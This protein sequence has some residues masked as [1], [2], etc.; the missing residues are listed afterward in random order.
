MNYQESLM[1]LD[2]LNTFGIKL[3]LSRIE[4]LTEL[5][6][7]PERKYKTIHV[8][9]TNGKGSVSC[10][11]AA[12]L[13]QA[14][15]RAGLYI[16]PHLISYTERCSVNGEDISESDF[17]ACLTKVREASKQMEREG[18]ESPT[19]FEV[20]T[21]L[22]FLWFA[23]QKV[24]YAVIEVGLGGLLDSTNIITP[25]LSI[26]TNVTLEHADR[27]GGTL[28]GV[29]EHKSGIIK[30]GVPVIT[31]AEGMPL[32]VIRK[33]AAEKSSKLYALGEDFTNE[34]VRF[35]S[36]VQ[37]LSFTAAQT[38]VRA[39][40]YDVS[41]LGDYQ[42]ANSSLA[43]MAAVLLSET[44]KGITPSVLKDA[45]AKVSWPGR[46]EDM[47]I[48]DQQIR[49]DGAHNPAGVKALR[50]ALDRYYPD[51]PRVFLLG[52]LADK[53][54]DEMLPV[55]LRP[56]DTLV[57]TLPDS[58]RAEQPEVLVEKAVV[59]HAE[60]EADNAKALDRALEL[61]GESNLLICAGSL[62]LIGGLRSLLLQKEH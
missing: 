37:E 6:G 44:E 47:S 21:A 11:T 35:H 58:T 22:A 57:A 59:R 17:A 23:E 28:E 50:T 42:I 10:M 33:T 29:A 4:R 27:C 19:Q 39:L 31:A 62:Y 30:K 52:I 60:A 25:A 8:T 2:E 1:Y 16:S 34:F 54:I 45:L 53:A 18:E 13:R 41:L 32:E 38:G 48:G 61:A 49:V 55:L 9:G 20:L 43:V 51:M 26:I 36:G 5:L 15:L 14:G 3:G 46:F 40:H 24:D 7:H 56:E 12:V